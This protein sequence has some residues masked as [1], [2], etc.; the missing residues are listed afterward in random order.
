MKEGR[1]QLREALGMY[2][3]LDMEADGLHAKTPPCFN[4]MGKYIWQGLADGK[5]P[6]AIAEEMSRLC[7]VSVEDAERDTR[8]FLQALEQAGIE[9]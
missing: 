4:E 8:E 7:D 2:W 9:Y 3:L 5:Q 1:Y 6:R